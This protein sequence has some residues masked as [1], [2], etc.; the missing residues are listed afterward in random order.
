MLLRGPPTTRTLAAC[1]VRL[2]VL[3]NAVAAQRRIVQRVVR[4]AERSEMLPPT[5]NGGR[6]KTNRTRQ[7]KSSPNYLQ[8]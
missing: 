4:D 6:G 1:S 2:R 8:Y 7:N 5:K 3:G